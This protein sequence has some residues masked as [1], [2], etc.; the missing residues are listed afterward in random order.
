MGRECGAR[1]PVRQQPPLRHNLLSGD[2]NWPFETDAADPDNYSQDTR[3]ASDTDPRQPADEDARG[4]NGRL[5]V[6][7]GDLHVRAYRNFVPVEMTFS[8]PTPGVNF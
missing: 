1:H 6:L 3:F 8:Y 4:H 5:N 7:F 2:T